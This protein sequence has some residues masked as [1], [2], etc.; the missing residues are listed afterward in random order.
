MPPLPIRIVRLALACGVALSLAACGSGAV[1]G[2]DSGG[3][4]EP[5]NRGNGAATNYNRPWEPPKGDESVQAFEGHAI[6]FL[7]AGD[8]DG[9]QGYIDGNSDGFPA[10]QSFSSPRNLLLFQAGI[11]LCRHDEDAARGWYDK[12]AAM[13]W[14][15]TK[16]NDAD[17]DKNMC[18]LYQAVGSAIENRPK[19]DF[20]CQPGDL[21][22]WTVNNDTL[23]YDDPRTPQDESATTDQPSG[24]AASPI[25]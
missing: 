20:A 16:K 19:G 1:D 8:C 25:G 22:S 14:A 23:R 17:E 7:H 15:G 4:A 10:W 3:G 5:A 6:G 21:P 2:P 11:A 18:P 9:A 12:A 24:D 13:G